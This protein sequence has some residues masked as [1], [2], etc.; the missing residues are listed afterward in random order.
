MVAEGA[1][2]DW[3]A[4]YLATVAE[5]SPPAAAAG[6]A[7]FSAAMVLGRVTGDRIVRALGPAR[8][9]MGGSVLAALGYALAAAAPGLAIPGCALI[10]IGLSNIVPVLFSAAG[11]L[12]PSPAT[13]IA[14][15]AT[16][17]YAGF[18][19]GPPVVGGV[20]SLTGLRTAFVLLALLAAGVAVFGARLRRP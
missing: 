9:A 10:G 2:A 11:R 4:V 16:A 14:M 6:Y 18:L 1:M 17:G 20:A 5:A 13:G 8:V 15:V 7:V 12:A 19:L 3:S